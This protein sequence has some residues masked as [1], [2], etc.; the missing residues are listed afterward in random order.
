MKEQFH[1]KVYH[2]LANSGL[3]SA[4]PGKSVKTLLALAMFM[5]EEG[6]CFP[7]RT[8]LAKILGISE[9]QVSNNIKALED[10]RFNGKPI[11]K[12]DRSNWNNFYRI[13][14]TSQIAIFDGEV[15]FLEPNFVTKTSPSRLRKGNQLSNQKVTLTRTNNEN[16]EQENIIPSESVAQTVETKEEPFKN[17][18]EIVKYYCKKYREKYNVNY[19][20]S[21][22]KEVP[23]VKNTL[24]KNYTMEQIKQIIDLSF[25]HYDEWGD[26]KKFPRLTLRALTTW[27]PNK[28]MEL[29]EKQ[30]QKDAELER[31]MNLPEHG[32]RDINDLFRVLG[33]GE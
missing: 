22:K 29:L 19:N 3:L 20:A 32:G 28:V 2:G 16:Q 12:V 24:V 17:A 13:L 4:L 14:P 8:R 23:I 5:N 9:K 30:I 33:G 15:E 25:E 18:G 27:L 11:I 7:S 10:F 1:I 6:Q 26:L 31:A 21:F